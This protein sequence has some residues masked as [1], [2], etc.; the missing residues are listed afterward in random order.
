MQPPMGLEIAARRRASRLHTA[1][2]LLACVLPLATTACIGVIG[3]E[4]P[5]GIEGPGVETQALRSPFPRLTHEQWENTVRD[6]LRLPDLSGLSA[7]FTGDP[8]GG[9]FDNNEVVLAVTPGLW[10]DY[11]RA[12]EVL[13]AMVVSDPAKFA[14]IVPPDEGQ[15]DTARART[16]IEQ[17]GRRTY[18]R[19]LTEAEITEHLDLFAQG[20]TVLTGT[21]FQTGV[22]IVLQGFLQSPHFVYRVEQSGKTRA[23]GLIPLTSHEVATK[24]SYLLWNTMPDDGLLDAAAAGEFNTAEGIRTRAEQMLGDVRARDVVAA[25]HRQLFD[26]DRYGDLYK[27]PA[28]FPEFTDQMKADLAEE[29]RLF[30]DDVFFT[31]NGGLAELLTSRTAFVTERTAPIYGVSGTFSNDFVKTELD[32]AQRSGILTRAGFLAANATS[33]ASDPIHRGVF[34]N[35]RVLCAKLPPPPNNVTPLPPSDNKTTTRDQVD[36]HTGEGTC[37]A[38]CHGTLINPAGFAF[39]NYNAIGAFRTTDN[40]FP[41]NAADSYPLGGQ[42]VSYNNAIEFSKLMAESTEAHR[43]WSRH[44][45]EFAYGRSATSDDNPFLERLAVASRDGAPLK[46]LVLDLILSDAFLTRRPVEAP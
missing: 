24:L 8:L 14:L 36:G 37:G 7:S 28:V 5:G 2:L 34:I 4:T 38:S 45:L 39:E 42:M 19:P 20:P 16:F 29:S 30:V 13:A 18:R 15:G 26:W 25:F 31:Q 35:L 27:D 1:T 21:P 40:T 22:E 41:V 44:W 9:I 43:C 3:D 32:P 6:L 12:A 23:D 10:A 17:F 11:Q 46:Q 33:R